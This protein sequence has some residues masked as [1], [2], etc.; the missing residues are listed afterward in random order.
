[1][2]QHTLQTYNKPCVFIL[3]KTKQKKNSSIVHT[4]TLNF[5]HCTSVYINANL[6]DQKCFICGIVCIVF[7]KDP[8]GNKVFVRI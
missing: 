8:L 2:H 7:L 3:E 5:L 1:M 6:N 4:N